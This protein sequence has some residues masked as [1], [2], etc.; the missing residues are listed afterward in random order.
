MSCMSK[1]NVDIAEF[2]QEQ[3]NSPKAQLQPQ[4]EDPGFGDDVRT[5]KRGEERW[6]FGL[7]Q[8]RTVGKWLQTC[9]RH[10]Y[11]SY[12]IRELTC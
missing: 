8:V 1:L 4:F 9:V 12:P 3:W 6:L 7:M 2:E 10:P 11:A 5:Q